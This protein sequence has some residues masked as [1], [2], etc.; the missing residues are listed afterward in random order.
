MLTDQDASHV[1]QQLQHL[2][3]TP[4]QSRNAITA[5]S[6][7]SPLTTHLLRIL[8]PL[9]AC[10]EYLILHVPECDLPQRFLPSINSSNAFV[11]SAHAGTDDLQRRWMEDKAVKECGWPL[12]VVKECMS[13]SVLTNDWGSLVAALNRRLLGGESAD[14]TVIPDA[15]E[16][17]DL[18]EVE[19]LAGQITDVGQLIIP[20]PVAPIILNAIMSPNHGLATRGVPPPM[21]ITSNSVPAYV[22]L[23][24]LSKSLLAFKDDT[25]IEE[26][27]S[28]LMATVRLLEEEW[29]LVEDNGPPPMS[30]VLKHLLPQTPDFPLSSDEQS[31]SDAISQ[32]TSGK[33]RRPSRRRDDRSDERVKEDYEEM[34][35]KTGYK[36]LLTV[37]EKL[38]AF[39]SKENFL[40]LLER[41]QCIVVVG[42]TG[43][44][45]L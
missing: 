44:R 24:L 16:H 1:L 27:E 22:R 21:Y 19:A 5:M 28:F 39:T 41:N 30:E 31:R 20:M 17:V 35:Q 10:I 37:R 13:E 34:C 23:H 26:G 36:Q 8:S 42:E 3:F 14:D 33:Q 12:H 29:A 32:H 7:P 38:P 45:L 40:D 18:E 11:T 43:N 6:T 25:L 15:T 2:N 4:V 9:Q